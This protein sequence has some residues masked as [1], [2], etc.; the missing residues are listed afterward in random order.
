[1]LGM[2]LHDSFYYLVKNGIAYIFGSFCVC[3]HLWMMGHK[4]QG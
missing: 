1:M 3:C 2:N 4:K